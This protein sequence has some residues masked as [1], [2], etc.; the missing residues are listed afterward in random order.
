[1]NNR[2]PRLLCIEDEKDIRELIVSELT[3][4][5]YEVLE[6]ADGLHGLKMILSEEP[7][8][9]LCDISMPGMTGYEV[10]RSL[11][12]KH[13]ELAHI[14]FIFLSSIFH[15]PKHRRDPFS[16]LPAQLHP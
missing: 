14:P 3:F 10:L 9:V 16:W 2:Q 7:D 13:K 8:L 5:G 15:Q 4:E 11:R 12:G 1:M 6:A